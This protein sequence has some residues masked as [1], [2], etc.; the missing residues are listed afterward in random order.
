[1]S[2]IIVQLSLTYYGLGVNIYR[3]AS[4][5]LKMTLWYRLDT[6]TC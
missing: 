5:G 2:F 6:A 1:M 3:F 4:F